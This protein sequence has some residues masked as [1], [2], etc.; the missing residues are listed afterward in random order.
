[1]SCREDG[2]LDDPQDLPELLL[3]MGGVGRNFVEYPHIRSSVKQGLFVAA[4]NSF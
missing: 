1:M 2:R 4:V 3:F